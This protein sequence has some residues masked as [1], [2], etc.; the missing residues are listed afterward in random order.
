M[1]AVWILSHWKLVRVDCGMD[2]N[3]G[4]AKGEGKCSCQIYRVEYI[5]NNRISISEM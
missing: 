3:V 2:M 4:H 1:I 5:G